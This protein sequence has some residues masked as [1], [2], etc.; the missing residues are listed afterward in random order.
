MRDESVD[1]LLL[2]AGTGSL[3]EQLEAET[4][5]LQLEDRVR[6]L[7]LRDDV[8]TILQC[9]DFL[10]L[11]S[12]FEGLPVVLVE[13]QAS[14]VPCLVSDKV[15]EDSDLGLGLL[16]FLPTSDLDA[17]VEELKRRPQAHLD[18]DLIRSALSAKGYGVDEGLQ[19]LMELYRPVVGT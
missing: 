7:G 6:F 4:E 12:H 1:F 13:A 16:T 9:A 14:G 15:T 2:L 18:A 3:R 19:R 8:A 5:S 11:P 10:L 17:W